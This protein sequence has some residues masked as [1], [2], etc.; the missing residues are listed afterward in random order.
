MCNESD[1]FWGDIYPDKWSTVDYYF[2]DKNHYGENY[3][4][5]IERLNPL[6]A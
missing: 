2:K 4:Y 1:A 6:T 3:N 5:L